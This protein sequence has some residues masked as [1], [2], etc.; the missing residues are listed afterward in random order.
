MDENLIQKNCLTFHPGKKGEQKVW[1][2]L[3]LKSISASV[4]NKQ[5]RRI[6]CIPFSTNQNEKK[7][8][9]KYF[10]PETWMFVSWYC[11]SCSKSFPWSTKRVRTFATFYSTNY[12]S[13]FWHGTHWPLILTSYNIELIK[14]FLFNEGYFLYNSMCSFQFCAFSLIWST[15]PIFLN[16]CTLAENARWT[17][18]L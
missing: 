17:S 8:W 10:C 13:V 12:D 5:S 2:K 3:K 15:F 7:H 14:L 1:K 18:T 9:S 16:Y 6:G 11:D 4:P